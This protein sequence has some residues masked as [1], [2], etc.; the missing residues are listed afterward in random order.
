MS[1]TNYSKKKRRSTSK[2]ILIFGEGL[3]EET[4]LKHL[5]SLYSHNQKFSVIIKRGKGGTADGIIKQAINIQ[6]AFNR[7]LV[8]LDNDKEE[9]EMNKA[10]KLAK[11]N[12]ISLFE[13]TP[14]LESLL[15]SIVNKGKKFS[16]RTTRWCKKEFESKHMDSRKRGNIN[17]HKNLFSKTILEEM[18][19]KIPELNTLISIF[20]G[21]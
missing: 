14:C 16:N 3:A 20:E 8:V 5:K 17:H 11:A 15:L 19:S 21:D 9:K 4:F 18:R 10:R 7:R 13:N 2:T 1:R 12:N 6:G